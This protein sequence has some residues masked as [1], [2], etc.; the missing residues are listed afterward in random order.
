MVEK[1]R[2]DERN[3]I[4]VLWHRNVTEGGRRLYQETQHSAKQNKGIEVRKEN[5]KAKVQ[6]TDS[7]F[8]FKGWLKMYTQNGT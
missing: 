2:W 7:D 4:T 1:I 6:E 5:E 3:L 8:F